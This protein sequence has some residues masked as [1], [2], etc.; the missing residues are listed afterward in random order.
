LAL[1]RVLL[2]VARDPWQKHG[3]VEAPAEARYA[4]VAAAIEG[5]DRL[6]ASRL[7]LD[8]D[9]PT[10]TAD[11]VAELTAPGRELFLIVGADVAN[12]LDTWDRIG[13]LQ[14]R[15]TLALVDRPDGPSP[16]SPVGWRT[17]S[18]HMP[19]LDIS[20]SDLR[21]RIAAGEPVDFL[22]PAPAVQI[23]RS[24]GLYTSR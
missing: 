16:A 5:V 14:E 6:E 24:R 2:M 18:V 22:I 10:Y 13:E 21:R 17:V 9:G 15:V 12:S 19:R 7:E 23:L 3:R 11:T 8:R 4:M 1:D 20:S